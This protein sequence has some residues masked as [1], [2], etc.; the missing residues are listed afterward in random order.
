MKWWKYAALAAV[1]TLSATPVV[2]QGPGLAPRLPAGPVNVEAALRMREQLKLTDSQAAQLEALRKELVTQRQ[3]QAREMIDL[4][5]R[6]A[7]GLLEREEMRKQMESRRESM[8]SALEQRR[9]RMERIL[10]DAQRE[11]LARARAQAGRAELR[12]AGRPPGVAPRAFE[13]GRRRPP[14]PG[15][16]Y[17]F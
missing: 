12:R 3:N 1:L 9:E 15:R 13:R 2:A 11:Q 16:Y 10:T 8:R 5:S 17:W 6:A 14:M 4:Q 7:A